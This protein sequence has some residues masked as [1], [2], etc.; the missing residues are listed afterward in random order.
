MA[1]GTSNVYMYH[2]KSVL[3]LFGLP[4]SKEST[5]TM[6]QSQEKKCSKKG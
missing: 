6:V 5:A 3:T 1:K 4:G 2:H